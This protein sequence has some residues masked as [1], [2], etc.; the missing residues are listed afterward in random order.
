[1]P[2]DEPEVSDG[3]AKRA[4]IVET[5]VT[6]D[7]HARIAAA[8]LR[9]IFGAAYARD[10]GLRF[11]LGITSALLAKPEDGGHVWLPLTRRDLYRTSDAGMNGCAE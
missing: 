6:D 8:I 5:F 3:L 1:M 4:M 2:Q 11:T 9:L 7:P 10:F